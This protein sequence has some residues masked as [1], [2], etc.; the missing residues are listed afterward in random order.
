MCLSPTSS[1]AVFYQVIAVWFLHLGLNLRRE[2]VPFITKQLI[3]NTIEENGV[4]T[5]DPM[6]ETCLDMM[7]RYA[8][9][10]VRVNTY[11]EDLPS[12]SAFFSN[13]GD[14]SWIY[15]NTLIT[16][17]ANDH[18]WTNVRGRGSFSNGTLRC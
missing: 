14:R 2:F 13:A 9:S 12:V 18:G 5:I 17:R 3:R 16:I 7:A 8:Y 1:L 10:D 6:V 11:R 15:G 4:K